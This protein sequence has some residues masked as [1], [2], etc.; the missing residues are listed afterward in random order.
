[1]TEFGYGPGV[2]ESVARLSGVWCRV[3]TDAEDVSFARVVRCWWCCFR[4]ARGGVAEVL[5]ISRCNGLTSPVRMDSLF[6]Q[7]F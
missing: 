7:E 3:G 1:M 6:V 5:E 2:L 4:S